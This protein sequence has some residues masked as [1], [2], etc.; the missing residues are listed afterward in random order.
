[1][2]VVLPLLLFLFKGAGFNCLVTG[3]EWGWGDW[4]HS[5]T[6]PG[7]CTPNIVFPWF[8]ICWI[9]D[10]IYSG[11]EAAMLESFSVLL[12]VRWGG[13]NHHQ[14]SEQICCFLKLPLKERRHGFCGLNCERLQANKWRGHGRR[15]TG[16][17][18]WSKEQLATVR[19]KAEL[20]NLSN[21]KQFTHALAGLRNWEC[22]M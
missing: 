10:D 5:S 22:N 8:D 6:N 18:A 14:K 2:R 9:C 13:K 20:Y 21:Q 4:G 19:S 16:V 11:G 3:D 12:C 1:M 7:L 17:W 15:R